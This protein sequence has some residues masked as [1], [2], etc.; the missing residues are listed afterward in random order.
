MMRSLVIAAAVASIPATAAAGTISGT[1]RAQVGGAA[2]G[3]AEVHGWLMDA[4]GGSL[5]QTVT[6]D[7]SGNYTLTLAAGTYRVDARGPASD[8]D[9][10]DRWYDVVAPGGAGYVGDVAD[11]IVVGPATTHPGTDI[12]LEV[13]GGLDGRVLFGGNPLVGPLVRFE[14]HADP[15]I[16]HTDY[17]DPAPHAGLAS[18]RGLPPA[19]DWQILVYDPTGQRDTLL[20]PGPY[21]VTAGVDGA[22][23]DLTMV[24]YP[25]DP[26]DPANNAPSCGAPLVS[27]ALLHSTPPQPWVTGNARIGP[28]G[29]SD[30]D[31]FCFQAVKWD[32]LLITASTAFSFN[33]TPRYHPY[34]DPLLSWWLG[35]GTTEL[36]VDDD[37]GPGGFSSFIDT[38]P[39][40]AGCYCAAVTTFGDGDFNGSGQLSTGRY[41]LTFQMGNRPPALFVRKGASEVP[42]APQTL[43][44]A[45]GQTLDLDLSYPDLEGDAVTT[46]FH[47]RDNGNAD[48]TSGTLVMGA[49]S[50]SYSFTAGAT[51]AQQSPYT[52]QVTAADAEFTAASNIILVVTEVND[53]PGLPVLISPIGGAVSASSTPTLTIGNATDPDADPL[54]YD[55]ELYYDYTGGAPA[56]TATV[57]EMITQT[58]WTPAPIAENT[59]VY[60]RARAVDDAGGHSPWTGFED[61]LVDSSNEPPDDPVL[62]KPGD[63]E[64][65]M[66]RRPG[67]SVLNPGEPEGEDVTIHFEIATDGDFASTVWTGSA[68]VNTASATTMMTVDADLDWGG[69]YWA[70]AQA[71][72][73]RGALSG[74]SNLRHFTIKANTPPGA[75]E[76]GACTGDKFT[77]GPPTSFT[78]TNPVDPEGEAVTLQLEIY[79]YDADGGLGD[80]VLSASAPM[81]DTATETAIPFDGSQLGDG[82]YAWRARATDGELYSDWTEP[83]DFYVVVPMTESGGCCRSGAGAAGALPLA[84]LVL[85]LVS[86][87]RTSRP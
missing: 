33:G 49:A 6:A 36:Q 81:D 77:E 68:P 59:R 35:Q 20:V 86:R 87:R 21:T 54:G 62:V 79:D 37:S 45:E 26:Y 13:L 60:W 24:S 12:N 69:S 3:G 27:A 51:A 78:V 9:Y 8:N 48:V 76:R 5:A 80:L 43:T 38:G 16:H 55:L 61:F 72:D 44:M 32:R 84:L 50:G 2:I 57:A 14:R 15:R 10:G 11:D 25:A 67:L 42:E 85:A 4:K 83:C 63:G 34:T 17:A 56:Q 41:A 30:V 18:F 73:A 70:R 46:S 7:G 47:H 28:Q 39:L 64:E 82:H 23:G 52:I 75:P 31:W 53:P 1:I 65:V 66:V 58:T 22:Y 29:A 71:E 19:T 40:A 74:Y